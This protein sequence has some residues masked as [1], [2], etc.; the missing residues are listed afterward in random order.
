MIEKEKEGALE[1]Q[2]NSGGEWLVKDWRAL[3]DLRK[4]T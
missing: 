4:K 3:V 1:R 2:G